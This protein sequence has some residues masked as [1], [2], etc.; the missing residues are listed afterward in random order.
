MMMIAAIATS[1]YHGKQT[2]QWVS[3][4]LPKHGYHN[5]TRYKSLWSLHCSAVTILLSSS[6]LSSYA[7]YNKREYTL[8]SS[9]RGPIYLAFTVIIASRLTQPL[10]TQI[11]KPVE[12]LLC[13]DAILDIELT[14]GGW[15]LVQWPA[16]PLALMSHVVS[17]PD[18]PPKPASLVD[19][20]LSPSF[21]L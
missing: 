2:K 11:G 7:W 12:N 3:E 8:S 9:S 21:V 16:Q 20:E 19:R 13:I 18:P 14:Q 1:Y 6:S 15:Q 17:A 4:E 5:A 10:L